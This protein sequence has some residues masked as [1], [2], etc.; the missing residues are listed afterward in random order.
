MKLDKK[1]RYALLIWLGE[2]VHGLFK[3]YSVISDF[4]EFCDGE[5]TEWRVI[6]TFG[7]AGK[8]WNVHEKIYITGYSQYEIGKREYKKQ[9]ELID[10]WNK[11]LEELMVT[12]G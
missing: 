11:E 2:K 1:Q 9:Q 8:I 12:Y 7:M 6:Y 5:I 10:K 3:D 4:D